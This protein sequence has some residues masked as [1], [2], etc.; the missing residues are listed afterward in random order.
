MAILIAHDFGAKII[1]EHYARVGRPLAGNV[2][3]DYNLRGCR[4]RR[5]NVQVQAIITWGKPVSV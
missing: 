5:S 4:I 3:T 2:E 1:P